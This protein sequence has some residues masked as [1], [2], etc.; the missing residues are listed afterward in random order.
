MRIFKLE[1]KRVLNTR[2]TWILL[3]LSLFLSVWM[4]YLPTTFSDI[5]YTDENG[6]QVE[7]T[8]LDSLHYRKTIQ[9][10]T[11]GEVTPDKIHKALE[12]YQACLEEYGV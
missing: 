9:A 10:D 3:A 1:L 11:A 4:A 5:S 8:G 7:L 12:A 6:D 2:M